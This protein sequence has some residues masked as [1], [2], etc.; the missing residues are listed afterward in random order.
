MSFFCFA[1]ELRNFG[2]LSRN[3]ALIGINF[4]TILPCLTTI[5]QGEV[6]PLFQSSLGEEEGSRGPEAPSPGVFKGPSHMGGVPSRVAKDDP[7][8]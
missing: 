5:E 1:L 3:L 6:V 2:R 8:N 4:A 7:F